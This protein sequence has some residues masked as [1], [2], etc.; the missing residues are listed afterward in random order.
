M[1][2]SFNSSNLPNIKILYMCAAFALPMLRYISE[3]ITLVFIFV[4][5]R[6]ES[7]GV[8]KLPRI[9]F[10]P[11]THLPPHPLEIS[12]PIIS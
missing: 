4:R 3:H 9:L 12:E 5:L 1:I 10:Q 7:G 8:R 2:T 11:L 6:L